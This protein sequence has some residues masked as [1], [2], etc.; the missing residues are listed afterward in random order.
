MSVNTNT[1]SSNTDTEKKTDQ[2]FNDVV[3]KSFGWIENEAE[4]QLRC[5]G[6]GKTVQHETTNCIRNP[7][8]CQRKAAIKSV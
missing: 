5:V 6:F 4:Q 2:R 8:S 1:N 3:G 7:E